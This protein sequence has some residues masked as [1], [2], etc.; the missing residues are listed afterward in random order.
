TS[1]TAWAPSAVRNAPRC[2]ATPSSPTRKP[3]T[4]SAIRSS[5]GH[6]AA[7]ALR[8]IASASH[9]MRLARRRKCWYP[10][11][12]HL[13]VPSRSVDRAPEPR[14]EGGVLVVALN[15]PDRRN[16]IDAEMATALRAAFEQAA[17]D[18]ETRAV[19]LTGEGGAFSAGGDLSRFD[20]DWDPREF[21]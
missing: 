15:R 5:T 3:A 16:A 7:S 13:T 20:K 1:K 11:I 12:T 14:D 10:A 2:S 17:D 19:I 4:Y 8:S 21:R 6:A 18:A 9:W